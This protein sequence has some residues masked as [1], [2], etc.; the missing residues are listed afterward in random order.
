MYMYCSSFV[1]VSCDMNSHIMFAHMDFVELWFMYICHALP[2][3]V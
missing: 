2:V 3:A 1:L